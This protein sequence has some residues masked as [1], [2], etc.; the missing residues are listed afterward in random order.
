MLSNFKTNSQRAKLSV[1]STKFSNYGHWVG[2]ISG[3]GVSWVSGEGMGKKA[4]GGSDGPK[5]GG[6]QCSFRDKVSGGSQVQ[7]TM[8][9]V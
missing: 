3:E 1:V 2:E 9:N 6:R 8:K 4:A 7:Y 5:G